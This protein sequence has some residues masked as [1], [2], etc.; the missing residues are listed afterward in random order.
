M[1]R[2]E[3]ENAQGRIYVSVMGDST[4]HAFQPLTRNPLTGRGPL[5]EPYT[6][7]MRVFAT[8]RTFL[9]TMPA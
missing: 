9:N 5:S 6:E 2:R 8:S 3:I 1:P 7:Q 4:Y